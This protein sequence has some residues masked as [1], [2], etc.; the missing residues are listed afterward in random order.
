MKKGMINIVF[1]GA[2]RIAMNGDVANK[3]GTYNH[4]VLARENKIPFYVVAPLSTFD[5][6]IDHGEEIVIE[7]R[8]AKEVAAPFGKYLTTRKAKVF[9][10]AF[11]VTPSN[12]IKGIIT[13]KGIIRPPYKKNISRRIK[14]KT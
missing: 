2:D 5:P 7:E 4:A 8:S 11:D 3:I 6:K 1:V 9:N 10:P 13:E 14:R 12:Y